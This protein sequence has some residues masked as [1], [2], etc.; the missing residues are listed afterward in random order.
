MYKIPSY[1]QEETP[2]SVSKKQSLG[3]ERA[4]A[5]PISKPFR[6]V[7]YSFCSWTSCL[8]R[9]LGRWAGVTAT[10]QLC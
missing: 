8:A 6:V 7:L 9:E 5:E 10:A 3:K 2:T 1:S 4:G